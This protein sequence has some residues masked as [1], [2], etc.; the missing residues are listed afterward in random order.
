MIIQDSKKR[1]IPLLSIAVFSSLLFVGVESAISAEAPL[2]ELDKGILKGVEYCDNG[3]KAL[4]GKVKDI[5]QFQFTRSGT[6]MTAMVSTIGGESF[7]LTG[8]ILANN[9]KKGVFQLFGMSPT[10]TEMAMNGKY[11]LN[12]DGSLKLV[13]G[14]FQAQDLTA[15]CLSAGSFKAK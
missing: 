8:N 14:A 1:L 6:I 9:S 10:G 5:A 4:K 3:E 7:D 13:G 11:V 15:L 12:K 2:E